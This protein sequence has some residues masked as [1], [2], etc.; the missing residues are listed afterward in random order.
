MFLIDESR[1]GQETGTGWRAVKEGEGV[2][3][4]L[5]KNVVVVEACMF[6]VH[7][8]ETVP[9]LQPTYNVYDTFVTAIV[10]VILY[11]ARDDHQ[12]VS[13]PVFPRLIRDQRPTPIQQ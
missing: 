9:N 11:I 1:P 4:L 3:Q 8:K 10:I 12:V 6:F 13:H 2:D 7:H 5:S